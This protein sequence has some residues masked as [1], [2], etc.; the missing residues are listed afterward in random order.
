MT[1]Y[2][3]IL[4]GGNM[5]ILSFNM[6][7]SVNS[8]KNFT[9]KNY[10]QL[11]NDVEKANSVDSF[12]CSENRVNSVYLPSFCKY[13][14]IGYTFLKDKDT[15]QLKKVVIQKENQGNYGSFRAMIDRK[16]AGRMDIKYEAV[17]PD[18]P[19]ITAVKEDCEI[20]E[21]RHIRSYLGDKYKGI[22]TTLMNVAVLESK[23]VGKGGRLW[24]SA[25]KGYDFASSEHRSMESPIPFYYKLGFRC[26][27]EKT[28][29]E[30]LKNTQEK[31][32]ENLP[33]EAL[34]SLDENNVR[35]LEN[36]FNDRYTFQK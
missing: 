16:E 32:Y 3:L 1:L 34:L 22:G 25:E 28:D 36:Y 20:P 11:R 18:M 12:N 19:K 7:N 4:F 27:D 35:V 31:K 10:G 8:L 21:V 6:S 29:K 14:T 23:R 17:Q 33:D 2:N 26:T 13:K 30:I 5:N 15:D 9:T 24:L